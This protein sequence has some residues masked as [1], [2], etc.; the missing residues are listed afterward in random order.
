M[1]EWIKS[2]IQSL[3][4]GGV[5]FL[6]FL[7]NVFPPIPSELIMPLA[8]FFSRQHDLSL[9]GIIAAGTLGSVAG[10][11]PLYYAGK[12]TGEQRLRRWCD[13]HGK[14]IGFTG[15]DLDQARAWF[16]RHGAKTVFLCRLVPGVRSLISVPAGMAEMKLG[17]F[18]VYTTL[19]SAIWTAALAYA[20]R[21]LAGNYEQVER[22]LGP[23]S[24]TIVA[25]IVVCILVRA[26]RLRAK[27]GAS[28]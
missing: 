16:D 7:E 19:G 27:A 18:L 21:A 4:Y 12:V 6:M 24:T 20:G 9:W 2:I 8:G 10:A 5:V 1:S 11:L 23:I 22:V 3:S 28:G 17:L 25:G 26:F 13:R 14:W 15:R